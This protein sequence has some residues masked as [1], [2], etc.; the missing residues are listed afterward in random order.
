MNFGGDAVSTATI[1]TF[2]DVAR[3]IGSPFGGSSVFV[4]SRNVARTLFASVSIVPGVTVFGMFATMRV[5]FGVGEFI[6]GHAGSPPL[7]ASTWKVSPTSV[8]EN[9]CCARSSDEVLPLNATASVVVL[10]APSQPTFASTGASTSA[11]VPPEL[12]EDVDEVDE[13]EVVP[14]EDDALDVE[15][16]ASPFDVLHAANAAVPMTQAKK[17]KRRTIGPL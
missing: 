7:W 3:A 14:E 5:W 15:D 12:D 17:T 2:T 8:F 6:I 16:V 9:P 13:D 10:Q 1:V 4:K 11:S